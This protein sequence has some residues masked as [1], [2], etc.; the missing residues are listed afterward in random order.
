MIILLSFFFVSRQLAGNTFGKTIF[1]RAYS[2]KKEEN[3]L[4]LSAAAVSMIYLSSVFP[5]FS[6]SP[7]HFSTTIRAIIRYL[8]DGVFLVLY[9]LFIALYS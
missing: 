3:D 2:K 9:S 1:S 8:T 5:L 4:L 7:Q 6:F